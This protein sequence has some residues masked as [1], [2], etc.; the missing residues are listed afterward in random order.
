MMTQDEALDAIMTWFR[1]HEGLTPITMGG[2]S[3]AFRAVWRQIAAEYAMD[4]I[5]YAATGEL[6]QG[7]YAF[8]CT[9]EFKAECKRF[10]EGA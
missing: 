3:M 5:I 6:V 7:V 10:I 1:M 2:W 4:C 8:P 9:E